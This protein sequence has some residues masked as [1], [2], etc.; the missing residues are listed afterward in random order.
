MHLDVVEGLGHFLEL[1]VVLR[2]DE[3]IEQGEATAQRLLTALGIAPAQLL[4]QAYIDPLGDI[5]IRG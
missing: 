3:S 2:D 1:E 4:A 5:V